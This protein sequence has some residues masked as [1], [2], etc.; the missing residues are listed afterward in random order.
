MAT[1]RGDRT[2]LVTGATGFIGR[3]LVPALLDRGY[4]VRACARRQPTLPGHER[5][6]Q[7]RCDLLQ[8]ATLPGALEGAHAAYYLVH[9]MGGGRTGFRTLDRLAA[10]AFAEA[11]AAAG[12]S[13]IVYLGGVAPLGRPSEH[14]ASRLEVGRILRAGKVPTIELRAAMIVGTGSASWQICRDLA[15]RLPAMVLPSWLDSRLS[16]LALEDAIRALV[17]ALELPLDGSA[18]F[19]LPGPDLLT[20]KEVLERIAALEGR[21]IASVSL[22]WLTPR[23][24]AAW[25]KLV[26]RADFALARELVFGLTDDLLPSDRRFWEL[27]RRDRL[28]SFDAAARHAL[29]EERR[30]PRPT[31]RLAGL[32]EALVRRIGPRLRTA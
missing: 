23:L 27:T 32:E 30:R 21:R 31:G 6:E 1:A 3:A 10:T 24:S 4:R 11:A 28:L 18:V 15:L 12:L 29:E 22:P 16:P 9:S 26:T 19:D 25:L 13:R 14:L 17:D 5:L 2:I 7:V 20:A 8:P